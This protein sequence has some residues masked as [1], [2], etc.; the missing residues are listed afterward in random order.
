MAEREPS[1]NVIYTRE[2]HIGDKSST[3][4]EEDIAMLRD[5]YLSVKEFIT[6][7][8]Y[9]EKLQTELSAVQP[10]FMNVLETSERDLMRKD[11]SIIVTGETS[12][13]KSS[14]INQIIGRKEKVLVCKNLPA[15][16][17]ICR[18][19]NSEVLA[20][21]AYTK[22]EQLKK[23]EQA[24]DIKYLKSL[25][26]KWTDMGKYTKDMEDIYFVDVFLPVPMLKGNVIMVDTP[27]IGETKDLDEIL[28]DFLPHAVS[29][30]FIINA[31]N[32]GGINEDRIL[33]ILRTIVENRD[34]MPCFDPGEAIFLTNKWDSIENDQE[35]DEDEEDSI[36]QTWTSIKDKLE[37]CWPSVQPEK[38]FRISLKEVA[39]GV[40][41][42]FTDDYV[43]FEAVLRK[44]IDNN[45]DK[46]VDFY[47]RFIQQFA[48]NAEQGTLAR[49]KAL[50][51]SEEEQ[52]ELILRNNE[53]IKKIQSNCKEARVELEVIKHQTVSELA[54]A[55]YDYLHSD[56]GKDDIINP[57]DRTSITSISYRNI[58]D[59]VHQRLQRG[60][61]SWCKGNAAKTLIDKAELKLKLHVGRIES[62][63]QIVEQ[64]IIGIDFG[65][66]VGFNRAAAITMGIGLALLPISIGFTLVFAVI[67][68]I[69]SLLATA[70]QC[71]ARAFE[72]YN[73]CISNISKQSLHDSFNK[74]FGEEFDKIVIHFFEET[75][76]KQLDSFL[77]R[78]QMLMDEHKAIKKKQNAFMRLKE[79]IERIEGQIKDF[80]EKRELKDR[81][82]NQP[83]NLANN[84]QQSQTQL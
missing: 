30:I 13:G 26:K 48:K 12:A 60:I 32:A 10:E 76:P 77:K 74:S 65:Y 17:R 33:K 2:H 9:D 24:E 75:F 80:G 28:M 39:K 64:E 43:R 23:E 40:K 67:S 79:K 5:I 44:T 4:S 61:S 72:V 19:R 55:L 8:D 35:S 22:D 7:D 20:I 66:N 58:D 78:N 14:L 38:I 69:F 71:R 37:K 47:F 49:L 42:I 29:F 63:I 51:R 16:A 31:G 70:E 81:Q 45:Q 34:K 73:G 41:S 25:V 1:V 53:K 18:I 3:S 56:R 21:K 62:E 11:C 27:G 59:E 84:A 83:M 68:F 82:I 6:C 54:D 50:E 57:S 36:S 15:T 52:K 46:R